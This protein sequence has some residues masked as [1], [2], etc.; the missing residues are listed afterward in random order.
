M[1]E[2]S[3]HRKG[4]MVGVIATLVLVVSL[5]VT[6]AIWN[7][8]KVGDNQILVTGDIY[9]KYTGTNQIKATNM[10][11]IDISNYYHY[12]VNSNMTLD[13][14]ST[15][16][17]LFNEESFDEGSDA[18]NFCEGIGTIQGMTFQDVLNDK[19]NCYY[20]QPINEKR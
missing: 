11:P 18:R 10:L 4:V 17:V 20:S 13:E 19:K 16:E 12:V 8:S 7:Y 6:F 9:M 1:K 14:L 15:C 2:S 3:N 5:G